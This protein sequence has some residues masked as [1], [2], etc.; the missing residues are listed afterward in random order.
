MATIGMDKL[1]YAKIT[2]DING[3]ETY[4]IPTILAKAIKSDRN[5]FVQHTLYEVIRLR[6]TKGR[7]YGEPFELIDWQEQIIRDLFGIVRR[8]DECRQFRTAYRITSYNVCYTKLLRAAL[9]MT[10]IV[11]K[12]HR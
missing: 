8:Y 6:H 7:W 9:G 5:N 12:K 11:D 4:G 3:E 1:Y 2:E 10:Q